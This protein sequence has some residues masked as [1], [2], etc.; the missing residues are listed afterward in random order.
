MPNPFRY[1]DCCWTCLNGDGTVGDLVVE[2]RRQD[3]SHLS[4][5]HMSIRTIP[6]GDPRKGRGRRSTM[7]FLTHQIETGE[8]S[9][10]DHCPHRC[11]ILPSFILFLVFLDNE[12][13]INVLDAKKLLANHNVALHNYVTYLG[14]LC[15]PCDNNFHSG[16]RARVNS[17]LALHVNITGPQKMRILHDAYFAASE[18][19]IRGYFAKVGLIGNEPPRE[20]ISRLVNESMDKLADKFNNRHKD[21]LEQY[22]H[23]CILDGVPIEDRTELV[24]PWWTCLRRFLQQ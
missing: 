5:P 2:T 17:E 3:V 21:D 19:S 22:L 4:L 14:H 11:H 12:S 8:L 9:K 7:Y 23:H 24:G 15:D 1:V 20:V 6:P 13:A 10:G 16:L 18:A